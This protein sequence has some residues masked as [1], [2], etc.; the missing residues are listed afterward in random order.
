MNFRKKILVLILVPLLLVTG[1]SRNIASNRYTTSSDYSLTL[2]GKV[3]SVRDV[4]VSDQKSAAEN[5]TGLIAGGLAG[6]LAGSTIGGG[7]GSIA[8]AIGG[9]VIGSTIG[10]FAE[11]SLNNQDALEYVIKLDTSE[12]NKD[13]PPL[14]N[15][16]S[17]GTLKTVNAATTSGLVTVVQGKDII[18]KKGDDVF[19][20]FA[21]NRVK[22]APQN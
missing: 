4:I 8:T 20:I 2:Q 18:H 10:F 7:N 16:L 17:E 1:C 14:V 3:I 11:N 9:A 19:V 22:V 6:G 21:N 12:I 5:D 13:L 15:F